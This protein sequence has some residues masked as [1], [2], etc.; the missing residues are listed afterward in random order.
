ML[1]SFLM[2]HSLQGVS[3]MYKTSD[4]R[5]LASSSRGA[6]EDQSPDFRIARAHARHHDAPL[7]RH[8]DPIR[9]EPEKRL[10]SGPHRL[11]RGRRKL[12]T[13]SWVNV[14]I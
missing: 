14:K 4:D 6:R 10:R 9:T 5:E 1:I 3:A 12:K 11:R 2:G 7:V 13:L 8:A